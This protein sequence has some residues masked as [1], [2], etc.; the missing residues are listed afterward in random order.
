MRSKVFVKGGSVSADELILLEKMSNFKHIKRID[1]VKDVSLACRYNEKMCYHPQ[2]ELNFLKLNV[3]FGKKYLNTTQ[4][5]AELNKLA[6][7]L[8]NKI[9]HATN[10]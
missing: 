8:N 3:E 6:I 2:D 4:Y 9:S 7:A 1:Y 10:S 5:E